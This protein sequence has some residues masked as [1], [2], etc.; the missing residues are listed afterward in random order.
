MDLY[1]FQQKEIDELRRGNEELR[2]EHQRLQLLVKEQE[3]EI[4]HRQ[5]TNSQLSQTL[6]DT[7]SMYTVAQQQVATLRREKEELEELL[8]GK[9]GE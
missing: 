4:D 1:L 6:E 3:A 9:H 5:Q 7:K 8:G 2:L